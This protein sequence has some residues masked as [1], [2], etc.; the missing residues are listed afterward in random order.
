MYV[1]MLAERKRTT[2][3]VVMKLQLTVIVLLLAVLAVNARPHGRRQV[4]SELY[5]FSIDCCHL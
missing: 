1:C 5:S 2:Q 3:H 4:S